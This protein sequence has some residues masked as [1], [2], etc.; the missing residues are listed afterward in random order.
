MKPRFMIIAW[1]GDHDEDLAQAACDLQDVIDSA[2]MGGARVLAPLHD[3][4]HTVLEEM[5]D[6]GL[7]P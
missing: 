3:S 7:L 1:P 6:E 4:I 5:L 2:Q